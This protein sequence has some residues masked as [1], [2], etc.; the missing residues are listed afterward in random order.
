[1]N[2]GRFWKR[3]YRGGSISIF[4]YPFYSIICLYIFFLFGCYASSCMRIDIRRVFFNL[5]IRM[6][7]YYRILDPLRIECKSHIRNRR[8]N[9]PG[10]V[11]YFY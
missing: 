10:H 8:I 6:E 9:Y 11:H 4:L 5:I 2:R 7:S 3:N 1:M